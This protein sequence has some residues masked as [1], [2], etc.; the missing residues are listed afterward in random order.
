MLVEHHIPEKDWVTAKYWT[1][2]RF[3][4]EQNEAEVRLRAKR[5]P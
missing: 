3:W 5:L 1:I 4:W 2:C